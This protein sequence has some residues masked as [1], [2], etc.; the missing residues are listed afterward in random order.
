MPNRK[1]NEDGILVWVLIAALAFGVM[2]SLA[3]FV[4]SHKIVYY[5]AKVFDVLGYPWRLLPTDKGVQ[6]A[7][8]LDMNYILAMRHAAYVEFKDWMGYANLALRPL[9][10]ILIASMTLLTLRQFK[11]VTASRLNTRLSPEKLAEISM[12]T[13]TEIAPVLAIQE[14]LVK[15][16]VKGW[17]RQTFP[18]EFLQKARYQKQPILVPN[19]DGVLTLDLVRLKGYLTQTKNYRQG[20]RSFMFN[21]H[22][23][24]QIVDMSKDLEPLR[25]KKTVC[26]VDRLSN[27]AK[28][29]IGILAPYAFS[30]EA[31]S[32][33]ES[34][35]VKDALNLSAY[36][37]KDGIPN[38][39]VEEAQEGFEK[40][41]KSPELN[42]LAIKHQW[43]YPFLYALLTLAQRR[44][45]VGTWWFI[46]LKPVNRV[47]FY[48]LNTVGRHTPHAEAA[49]CF[50]QVQ[51]DEVVAKQGRLPVD[52]ELKSVIYCDKVIESFTEEWKFWINAK[53]DEVK[54][55][56]ASSIFNFDEE[57]I[58]MTALRDQLTESQ[59]IIPLP[60]STEEN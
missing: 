14:K 41:R 37:S 15:N 28:A 39:A 11:K 21:H 38:L 46:W 58:G 17:D 19:K 43:E 5:T 48:A 8:D 30:K 56:Q 59:K 9:S 31:S 24:R 49:M 29:L 34:A 33:K 23:G 18:Q 40:W 12:S 27:E 2:G 4:G 52:I 26:F 45:K 32:R 25:A 57:A 60:K 36:G 20:G 35:A 1:N 51:F 50:S 44:G 42:R 55:E 13:F 10:Y 7:A 3:W 54:D 53:G 16:K 47:M 6:A 22:L